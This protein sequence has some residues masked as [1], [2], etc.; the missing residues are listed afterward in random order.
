VKHR[1]RAWAVALST[2]VWTA[3]VWL[4]RWSIRR[5]N[6]TFLVAL[7]SLVATLYGVSLTHREAKQR[8]AVQ[9]RRAVLSIQL[10]S[11]VRGED[12]IDWQRLVLHNDGERTLDSIDWHL[13]I[14]KDAPIEGSIGQPSD[15][16]TI[17]GI[18][19]AHRWRRHIVS[20]RPR[21]EPF[22]I[23]ALRVKPGLADTP[24]NVSILWYIESDD[25][26]F[27]GR[28]KDGTVEYGR[29]E[30]PATKPK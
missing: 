7:A 9:A 30:I 29:I 13:L 4:A 18:V 14:P 2:A 27:P 22:P 20:L 5:W 16:V 11:P 21:G 24:N 19:Y 12:G 28:Q 25:G 6:W 23:L 3:I 8:E 17:D 26:T 10:G 1:L 15:D